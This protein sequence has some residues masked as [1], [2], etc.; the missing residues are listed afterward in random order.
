MS[1][2]VAVV[3][4]LVATWFEDDDRWLPAAARA[5]AATW[6]QTSRPDTPLAVE[7]KVPD[8]AQAEAKLAAKVDEA[9]YCVTDEDCT[10]FDYGY[11]IQ[12]LTSVSTAEITAL[13]LQYV[14]YD[15]SCS[16]RVYY[17]CP[18]GAME[19]LPVCR[20][21]RCEVELV[22]VEPL[23]DETLRHLGIQRP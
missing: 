5:P 12:C 7:T 17:D 13:R 11:P 19:R 23:Q 10:L 1:A 3:L 16:F 9:R 4:W 14:N 15:Q 2:A 8:C 6:P 22:G 18:S 20:N 21:Q